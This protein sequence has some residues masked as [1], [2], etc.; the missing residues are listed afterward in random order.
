MLS[1]TL[2]TDFGLAI[3]ASET[4]VVDYRIQTPCRNNR[5]QLA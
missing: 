3:P 4:L 5:I 1:Q 2:P